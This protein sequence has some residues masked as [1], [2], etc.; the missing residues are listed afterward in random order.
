M[1]GDPARGKK[2]KVSQV[3]WQLCSLARLRFSPRHAHFERSETG[4]Q[5]MSPKEY[6]I[7]DCDNDYIHTNY[8]TGVDIT[9]ITFWI[10]GS[11]N[12]TLIQ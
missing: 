2:P 12:K 9:P 4:A 10:N 6:L 11:Y 5:N 7:Y 8:S 1:L 3:A